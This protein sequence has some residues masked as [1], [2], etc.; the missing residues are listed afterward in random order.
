MKVTG[1]TEQRVVF[2]ACNPVNG[3]KRGVWRGIPFPSI[4]SDLIPLF[5]FLLLDLP[6][7]IYSHSRYTPL[8]MYPQFVAR[9]AARAISSEEGKEGF[10]KKEGPI[11]SHVTCSF[12]LFLN[13]SR[14]TD[15]L[16]HRS[17]QHILLLC[18]Q[19]IFDRRFIV[20]TSGMHAKSSRQCQPLDHRPRMAGAGSR[21]DGG[22]S[23]AKNFLTLPPKESLH[24]RSS[25]LLQRLRLLDRH[26]LDL[27][28][29]FELEHNMHSPPRPCPESPMRFHLCPSFL[30]SYSVLVGF[31]NHCNVIFVAT[32]VV[33]VPSVSSTAV[34]PLA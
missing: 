28:R 12:F 19:G 17:G 9:A 15:L 2:S 5:A 30:H 16:L 18:A 23:D 6:Q 14:P 34:L 26:R 31:Y 32:V 25:Y 22:L 24:S 10:L 1:S 7:P 33:V 13:A 4:R 27:S 20:D 21:W 11:T 8:P 29:H 3:H